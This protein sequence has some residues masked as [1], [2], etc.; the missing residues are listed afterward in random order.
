MRAVL[1]AALTAVVLAAPARAEGSRE[2]AAAADLQ[3]ICDADHGRLWG[4]S[5]CGPLLVV[6][7]APRAAWANQQDAAGVL[8]RDGAGWR[9]VLPDGIPVANTSIEWGG[10]RWIMVV[11]PLPEDDVE[12]RVLVAHEA[13]HRIQSALGLA[14]QNSTCAHLETERGRYL[15]RLELRAL[16]QA[17]QASGPA[18]WRA[19][20]DAL[21]F[22][23]ARLR[24]F[25]AA[26]ADEAALDR[27]EGLASYTG[28]KLGAGDQA[29]AYAAHTLEIYDARDAY[30]RS[31]AYASGPAYG[32][33][34]D[35]R[36]P[37]WRGALGAE[38]PAGILA[39]AMAERAHFDFAA[40]EA[41]YG[42]AA[43]AA[44]EHERAEAQAA[45][46][47]VLRARYSAEPRLVL[48]LQ[49]MQMEFNP[50]AVTPIEG[51]GGVYGVLTIRDVWG[52]LR[53][54][55]G[56]LISE[57]F[58]QVVAAAPDATGL[59]GPGWTLALRPGYQVSAPDADGVRRLEPIA[60]AP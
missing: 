11:A 31:Y 58:Q 54:T 21:A 9:G 60:T 59:A 24:E 45:R 57:D 36:R 37:G 53:A 35:A 26:A 41:R 30:A 42:G 23:S 2:E 25:P 55:E 46:V 29:F 40:A 22:R 51:L 16:R 14:A 10:Q 32:L 49:S 47:A 20:R 17:L 43:L 12:L 56:A 28:V 19:A 15:L 5:L 7:G 6:E 52:E 33:L 4:L 48:A 38:A 3:D 44:Q 1:I 34:L 27:N 13:W 50:N 39:R 8:T 18:R